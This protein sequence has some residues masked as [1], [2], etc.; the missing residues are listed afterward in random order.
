MRRALCLTLL[1]A[2]LESAHLE[3]TARAETQAQVLSNYSP[4]PRAAIAHFR[5]RTEPEH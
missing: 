4:E 5:A 2:G 1:L 3:A